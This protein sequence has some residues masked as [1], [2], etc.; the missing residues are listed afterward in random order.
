MSADNLARG[1]RALLGLFLFASAF[2]L[3]TVSHAETVNFSTELSRQYLIIATERLNGNTDVGA[4]NFELGAN[5]APVP[6]NTSFL[7]SGGGPTLEGAVPDLP[8]GIVPVEQGIGGHGNIAVTDPNGE[9]ELQDV[10]VYADPGIGIRVAAPNDSFNKSSNTFFNDPN[11]FPNTFDVNTQTGVDVNPNDADQNTRVDPT[12]Q[13]NP[14]AN[15]GITYGFDHTN[16][17]AELALARTA[18]NGLGATNVLDVSG[19]NS[20]QLENNSTITGGGNSNGS[21]TLTDG[22]AN[23]LSGVT[24]TLTLP[25]GL[26]VIDIETDENDFL[27]SEANFIIDGPAGSSVI[28]RL[29][30]GESMLINNSNILL[31]DGGIGRNNIL[32][33]TDQDEEST[34]FS[35]S[36]AILNGI[37]LWS[38]GDNGGDINVSNSQGSVQ[39]VADIV[40]MDDVRFTRWSFIGVPEPA[41]ATVLLIGIAGYAARRRG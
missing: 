17:L 19:G 36:N 18:I 4:N 11:M 20:G 8:A 28:F 26:S 41:T 37:A 24:Q 2:S 27:I 35:V 29:P 33:Y 1:L 23:S 25:E 38:L 12:G 32:F 39:L 15:V 7:N 6:A 31:G 22:P 14:S 13:G 34:H 5:K 9:F 30:D 10:G 40:D 3:A 16:L 21:A